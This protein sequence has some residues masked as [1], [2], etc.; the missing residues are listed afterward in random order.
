MA[1]ISGESICRSI[2]C[3]VL[4]L[5]LTSVSD[6]V[7]LVLGFWCVGGGYCGPSVGFLELFRKSRYG[8]CIVQ[9]SKH[10]GSRLLITCSWF[11]SDLWQFCCRIHSV[12]TSCVGSSSIVRGLFIYCWSLACSD[13]SIEPRLSSWGST[14][15]CTIAFWH[16]GFLASRF[17]PSCSLCSTSAPEISPSSSSPSSSCQNASISCHLPSLLLTVFFLLLHDGFT[18]I[19]FVPASL[20]WALTI[21]PVNSGLPLIS[22]V[23]QFPSC[24]SHPHHFSHVCLPRRCSF[25]Q[26]P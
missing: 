23:S 12:F 4:S 10:R 17:C 9:M 24:S 8:S 15:N 3:D 6:R 5:G 26:H 7:L 13:R 21:H 22:Q 2:Q 1:V 25:H 11:I 18:L 19:V 16:S 20:L 14:A